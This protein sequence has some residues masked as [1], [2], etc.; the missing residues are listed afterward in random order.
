AEPEV[1]P[2][3]T[4]DNEQTPALVTVPH[5]DS[6]SRVRPPLT[7]PIA[8]SIPSSSVL[9]VTTSS[10]AS[11]L[12]NQSSQSQTSTPLS[13][14]TRQMSSPNVSLISHRSSNNVTSNLLRHNPVIGLNNVL[15]PTQPHKR[16]I[17][18]TSTDTLNFISQPSQNKRPK[19]Y[20]DKSLKDEFLKKIDGIFDARL[21]SVERT[22]TQIS[23]RLA[24]IENIVFKNS[25]HFE[26][27]VPIVKNIKKNLLTVKQI[28]NGKNILSHKKAT[29]SIMSLARKMCCDLFTKDEL[30]D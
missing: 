1:V 30:L 22:L 28:H 2:L 9:P 20:D 5:D 4:K 23:T 15:Q 6:I 12:L 7:R 26:I 24:A 16:H 10:T 29:T 13:P 21:E 27:I 8:S 3:A 14:T 25:T 17:T 11:A 19:V 18:G